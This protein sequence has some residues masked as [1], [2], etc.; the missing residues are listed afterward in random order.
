MKV[1]VAGATG[2]L[3][4][5]LVPMLVE[6]GH[7]VV[8]MTRTESKRDQLRH[9]GAEPVVADALDAD[10]VGRAVGEAAPDVI[11]HQLTA[12]PPKINMRRF[13]R[14]F[15]LTNRLRT[16]GTDHLLSSGPCGRREAV[17]RPEQRRL[18]RPHRRRG[19]AGGGSAR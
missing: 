9:V 15:A 4:K 17:R 5:Q 3:G 13:D 16:E 19:Q 10:A 2:A 18:V 1:F 8:G 12:I 6:N 14:E 7:H 11:V